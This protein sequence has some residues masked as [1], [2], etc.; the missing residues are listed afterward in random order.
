MLSAFPIY[1]V[2]AKTLDKPKIEMK[3]STDTDSWY[4][5]FSAPNK[6]EKVKYRFVWDK[7]Y[8]SV[9]GKTKWLKT[10]E[11]DDFVV[12]I[13]DGKNSSKKVTYEM[14]K[15]I[16]KQHEA[17]I[18]NDTKEYVDKD[19]DEFTKLAQLCDFYLYSGHFKYNSEDHPDYD[20]YYREGACDY[21]ANTF[22]AA[23]KVYGIRAEFMFEKTIHA[24][25]HVYLTGEKDP[26]V[27]APSSLIVYKERCPS[28]T[29]SYVRARHIKLSTRDTL[30]S[31]ASVLCIKGAT[32]SKDKVVVDAGENGCLPGYEDYYDVYTYSA[33]KHYWEKHEY[34]ANG[35]E[36]KLSDHYGDETDVCWCWYYGDEGCDGS[37]AF[38]EGY[39]RD[40]E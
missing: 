36:A 35:I 10:D 27:V 24:W 25:T 40:E 11:Y 6:N 12:Y 39:V 30:K 4:V 17:D 21:L 29:D 33:E 23:C 16:V 2:E 37:I 5:R 20:W 13:T 34:D 22:I 3:Y 19:A 1:T 7:K 9:K 15:E 26:I 18:L 8:I 14:A 31:G 38:T 28:N 32:Y